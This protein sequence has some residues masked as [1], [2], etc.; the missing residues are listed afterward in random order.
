M[1]PNKYLYI[2]LIAI[3]AIGF[4]LLSAS[5]QTVSA[6]DVQ[7]YRDSAVIRTNAPI[8][9][10]D[11]EVINIYGRYSI[12]VD[13]NLIGKR[14]KFLWNNKEMEGTIEKLA[15]D[16]LIVKDSEGYYH[17]VDISQVLFRDLEIRRTVLNPNGTVYVN[18]GGLSWR[19]SSSLYL[20]NTRS[21]L[22]TGF[23]ITNNNRVRFRADIVELIDT[24]LNDFLYSRRF[25]EPDHKIMADMETSQPVDLDG[26]LNSRMVYTIR[27]LDIPPM[28]K[29]SKTVQSSEVQTT[30]IN[31]INFYLS[32]YSE[33]ISNQGNPIL[34]LKFE[35]ELEI[36]S[37]NID[38]YE[39]N[40]RFVKSIPT[41]YY[42]K[43]S[44]VTL[45]LWENKKVEYRIDVT[46]VLNRC[47]LGT[48]KPILLSSNM[49]IKLKNLNE[50]KERVDIKIILQENMEVVSGPARIEGN[51]LLVTLELS[52]G[53]ERT[54]QISLRGKE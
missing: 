25:I 53:E 30:R 18:V 12:Y 27:N 38:I 10:N 20:L 22:E 8:D 33:K 14:V 51:E 9:L 5:N 7:I 37:G 34:M 26:I 52:P 19:G 3:T 21:L 29:I 43:G 50:Q 40:G 28:S 24:N 42:P 31:E 36:P 47:S 45:T 39:E 54:V 48:C 4:V 32:S 11:L 1:I 16:I 13:E 23:L 49:T 44:E 41:G 46:N 35:T 2:L 17:R 6:A 15:G